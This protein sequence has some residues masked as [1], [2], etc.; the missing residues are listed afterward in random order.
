[1]KRGLLIF[2]M[3]SMLLMPLFANG[4]SESAA[5]TVKIAVSAPM[6]GDMGEYGVSFK[7]SIDL[8]CENW[9]AKGGV[10]GKKIVVEYGDS[11][12]IAQEAA[13]LA[14]K[15]TSDKSIFAQ[16]GDFTSACCMSSQS[17]Y[18]AAKM[19][20]LSPTA[21]NI[22]FA[23]GSP[24]SF[25]VLG[26]QIEQGRFMADWA[27]DDG[28]RK[29]AI[30][31]INSDWGVSVRD[32]FKV[33]FE[34]RGGKVIAEEYY[35]DSERDFTAVLTKLQAVKPEAIYLA[36]YYNDGA[37]ICVQKARLGW[38]TPT[39]CA[40]TVYSP[41]FVEL[42]GKA[43]E[44]I[45]T[46]VGFFPADPPAT[47]KEFISKYSA[48]YGTTPDYYGACAFD[49]FNVLM[50]AIERAGVLDSEIVR[51]ELLKTKGHEGVSGTITFDANG[52]AKKSYIKL[53]IRNGEF[54]AI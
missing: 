8:A 44:N 43:V 14:Q 15:F 54:C 19:I 48:K 49:A 31:Y 20:Q 45:L 5:D 16:I 38:E 25:E 26:T 50:E 51:Q 24:W 30:L 22:F 33:A 18:D 23:S 32:G 35:F 6:T 36:S 10:I 42:G 3:A 9:N 41:K 46:N 39:Y 40:G 47:A 28:I 21:S 37:A 11:K 1:M 27:Y 29:I 2:I 4:S 53:T 34:A 52:D 12:G 7:R 13:T 17:I